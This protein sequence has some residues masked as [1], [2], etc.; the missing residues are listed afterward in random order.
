MNNL[1]HRRSFRFS[2]DLRD[3]I[4]FA[5]EFLGISGQR[6]IQLAVTNE[7]ADMSATI[8][9]YRRARRQAKK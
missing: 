6:F 2:D 3:D 8:P 9:A 7:L 1:N 4:A 5:A